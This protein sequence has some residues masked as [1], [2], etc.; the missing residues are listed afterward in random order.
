MDTSITFG[1]RQL[2]KK[3]IVR[4]EH[5]V[6]VAVNFLFRN[7]N[8]LECRLDDLMPNMR[9]EGLA[10]GIKQKVGD[11]GAKEKVTTPDEF[12]A[13]ARAMWQRF[14]DGTAFT[15]TGG[16]DTGGDLAAALAEWKGKPL[17]EAQAFV[18]GLTQGER[19][20][21][22]VH[23]A[24]KPIL[25]RMARDKAGDVGELDDKLDEWAA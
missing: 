20:K 8:L 12:E 2:C 23:D 17:A 21:L 25:D 3:S 4:D 19:N 15:R 11:E 6:P 10:H 13:Q 9:I 5:G 16:I 22:K 18:K 14:L 1:V 24:I 7:G